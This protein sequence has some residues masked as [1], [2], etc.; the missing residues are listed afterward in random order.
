MLGM[1]QYDIEASVMT[2]NIIIHNKL[3]MIGFEEVMS[4]VFMEKR[5]DGYLLP[6]MGVSF[7]RS[8]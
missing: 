3:R 5:Y 8:E 4:F 6:Q 2:D 1:C 7:S